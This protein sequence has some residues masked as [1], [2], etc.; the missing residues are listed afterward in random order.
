MSCDFT[1]REMMFRVPSGNTV[2]TDVP[3]CVTKTI[4]ELQNKLSGTAPVFDPCGT[5]HKLHKDPRQV[6]RLGETSKTQLRI[7]VFGVFVPASFSPSP[8]FF[9]GKQSPLEDLSSEHF[10]L[11]W[12]RDMR[13]HLMMAKNQK[14]AKSPWNPPKIG[15]N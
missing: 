9:Q 15:L 10:F 14:F 5:C 7:Q 8:C 12:S 3:R 11:I 4:G 1:L 2:K 13:R 6:T